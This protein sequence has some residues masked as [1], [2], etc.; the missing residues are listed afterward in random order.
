VEGLATGDGVVAP[1][2][3]PCGDCPECARGRDEFC[4]RF[5]AL[6]RGQGT[7]FDGK[8]RLYRPDG[9]P[10][11][12]NAMSGLAELAV[13]PATS[14]FPAPPRLALADAAPIGCAVFTAFGAARHAAQLCAGERV[15]VVAV[16]G[17]GMS[18]VQVARALGASQVI[19]IDVVASKLEAAVA[20]GATH[21]IDGSREDVADRVDELTD[22]Q[23]VDVAFEALG[24]PETLRQALG[25]LGRGGRCVAIGVG[26]AGALTEIE[27]NAIVRS[28]LRLIGSYGARTRADMP[29]LLALVESGAIRPETSISRRVGL[30]EVGE[31]FRAMDRAEIVGRAIVELN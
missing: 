18:L 14:V 5:W 19:A 2:I 21:T 22:G 8:T 23:G 1:F 25:T 13:V 24:R 20:Q 30:D 11:W 7:L 26:P 17:V 15:A 3:L 16:G 9:E 10:V 28:E 27:V 29:E 12:M 31:A 6:N 4:A